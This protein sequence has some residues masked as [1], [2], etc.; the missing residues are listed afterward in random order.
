MA[1]ELV[2]TGVSY[3]MLVNDDTAT[4][5]SVPDA[6]EER[7]PSFLPDDFQYIPNRDLVLKQTP[8]FDHLVNS[9]I[10]NPMTSS[11]DVDLPSFKDILLDLLSSKHSWCNALQEQHKIAH[12][13]K[14]YIA[15]L[16]TENSQVISN[17]VRNGTLT[18]EIS[19]H[20]ASVGNTAIEYSLKHLEYLKFLSK[21]I[22]KNRELL[23]IHEGDADEPF[24]IFQVC[25]PVWFNGSGEERHIIRWTSLYKVLTELLFTES[26]KASP[27]I[28]SPH[29]FSCTRYIS[30]IFRNGTIANRTPPQYTRGSLKNIINRIRSRITINRSN[31]RPRRAIFLRNTTGTQYATI[32]KTRYTL[33]VILRWIEL[34]HTFLFRDQISHSIMYYFYRNIRVAP[35]RTISAAMEKRYINANL[36]TLTK[37]T[38][39]DEEDDPVLLVPFEENQEVY[40]M[41]CCKKDLSMGTILGIIQSGR[42]PVCPMCRAR[43]FTDNQESPIDPTYREPEVVEINEDVPVYVSN[44]RIPPSSYAR[45]PITRES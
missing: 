42:T 31:T 43:L 22:E 13:N 33:S 8:L 39:P 11:D 45:H 27:T 36:R 23:T 26:D 7:E 14:N 34:T 4:T 16:I 30:S 1:E 2:L 5:I 18:R 3:E 21:F 15:N 6:E 32:G 10:R 28:P 40:K 35:I 12:I 24:D 38:M 9:N 17:H 29:K 41:R 44:P 19:A 20:T 37:D 25:L